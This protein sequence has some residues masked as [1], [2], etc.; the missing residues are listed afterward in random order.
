VSDLKYTIT[1][2]DAEFKILDVVFSD[3]GWANIHLRE[4]LPINKEELEKVIKQFASPIEV[5]QAREDT[6]VDLSFIAPLVGTQ[7]TTTRFSFNNPDG[8]MSGPITPEPG[9]PTI[10]QMQQMQNFQKLQQ[11]KLIGDFLVEQGLLQTNPITQEQ[12]DA[13]RPTP[14]EATQEQPITQ[15]M[16]EL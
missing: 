1:K 2:W 11:Q 12:L 15:G 3:N 13:A 7:Y 4:P 14:P 5:I 10:D 8:L 6:S 9:Q 16:Q